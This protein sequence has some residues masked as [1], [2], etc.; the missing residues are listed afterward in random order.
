VFDVFHIFPLCAGIRT[1]VYRDPLKGCPCALW[2]AGIGWGPS[3]NVKGNRAPKAN[4]GELRATFIAR[5][6]R[7]LKGCRF[8]RCG[9]G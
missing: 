5:Q 6:R 7:V 8:S 9:K 1:V 4:K 3:F 2:T